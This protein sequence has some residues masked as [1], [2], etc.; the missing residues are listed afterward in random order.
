MGKS[1]IV[2]HWLLQAERDWRSVQALFREGQYM[3][4]LFFSHLV[5]E[6]LLK[7]HWVNNNVENEA[8]RVHDLEFL[9]NQTDLSMPAEQVEF[10]SIISS[11]NLE[12][13][14]Q[15]YKD[16]FYQRATRQYTEEKLNQVD[17]LRTWLQLQ[18]Q[19]N[20]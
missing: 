6:K 4:A 1:E 20:G 14:Y 15:D 12:G 17:T 8:P 11:W 3:H 18:L 2:A 9:Y 13:R 16:K 19:N 10:L 7:A 5:V